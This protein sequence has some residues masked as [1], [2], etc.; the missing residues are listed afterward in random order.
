MARTTLT[1]FTLGRVEG[2]LNTRGQTKRIK[3]LDQTSGKK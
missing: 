2:R 3:I 1:R